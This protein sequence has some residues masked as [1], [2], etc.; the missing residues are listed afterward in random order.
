MIYA[1]YEVTAPRAFLGIAMLR[2]PIFKGKIHQVVVIL[3]EHS[4]AW[5][6]L[7]GMIQ[8]PI[9]LRMEPMLKRQL[10]IGGLM[11]MAILLS[12]CG[13][14]SAAQT[15]PPPPRTLNVTG[16]GKILIV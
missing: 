1:R 3:Q 13:A 7:I 14:Q 5:W 6:R 9:R 10:I 12:A 2:G 15:S 11:V 16:S 8:I 4:I